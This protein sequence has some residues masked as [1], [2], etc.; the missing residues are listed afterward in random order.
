VVATVVGVLTG[1]LACAAVVGVALTAA[2]II[3]AITST[4]A[5]TTVVIV[6]VIIIV[7]VVIIAIIAIAVTAVVVAMVVV[8]VITIIIM[9]VIMV[10]VMITVVVVRT[11]RLVVRRTVAIVVVVGVAVVIVA[12]VRRMTLYPIRSGVIYVYGRVP[13]VVG[14]PRLVPNYCVIM[15]THIERTPQ[16]RCRCHCNY[17][18]CRR[19]NVHIIVVSGNCYPRTMEPLDSHLV[20]IVDVVLYVVNVAAVNLRVGGYC[21]NHRHYYE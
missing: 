3:V 18:G 16:Y 17:R 13:K 2:V 4:T 5:A 15:R 20:R 8:I 21:G 10:V 7:I 19:S 1:V 12:I 14:R 9:I 11:C 6:V